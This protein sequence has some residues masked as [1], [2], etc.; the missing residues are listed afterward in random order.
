[1]IIFPIPMSLQQMFN[2]LDVAA[3]KQ[4]NIEKLRGEIFK[5]F[6]YGWDGWECEETKFMNQSEE[7]LKFFTFLSFI[8]MSMEFDFISTRKNFKN[9]NF[10]LSLNYF[11]KLI[12]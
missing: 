3:A 5:C 4:K 12:I 10:L 8:F 6:S 2:D 11:F 9:F 7:N 1:M